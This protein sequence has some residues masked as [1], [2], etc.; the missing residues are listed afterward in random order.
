MRV[1]QSDFGAI[2]FEVF[3]QLFFIN[4]AL[5]V[6]RVGS[7]SAKF[8]LNSCRLINACHDR[9]IYSCQVRFNTEADV[10]QALIILVELLVDALEDISARHKLMN[11]MI[12]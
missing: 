10:D 9:S 2:S 3:I 4:Y 12:I 11:S 5:K 6:S 7:I 1:Y 8:E